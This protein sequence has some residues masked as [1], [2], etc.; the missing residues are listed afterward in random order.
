MSRRNLV[1]TRR[2]SIIWDI[3]LVGGVLKRWPSRGVSPVSVF[4]TSVQMMLGLICVL[5]IQLPSLFRIAAGLLLGCFL[6]YRKEG[7]VNG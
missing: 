2:S 6:S 3:S 7:N 4:E 5:S 1:S